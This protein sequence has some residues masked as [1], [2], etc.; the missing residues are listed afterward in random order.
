MKS[1]GAVIVDDE[2]IAR[3]T[4]SRMLAEFPDVQ[5][6]GQAESVEA[7]EVLID[8]VKADVVYLDIELIGESGFDL[9]PLLDEHV[10]VVFVTAFNQYAIRAFEVN[11]LDYLLKPVTRERLSETI[12]RLLGPTVPHLDLL[13]LNMDDVIL[14]H[15]NRRRRWLPIEQVSLIEASA[16]FTVIRSVNGLRATVWRPMREWERIL[17]A[18]QFV[19]IH[20]GRI[21]NLA[22]VEMFETLA[23]NRLQLH[24][25][26][27]NEACLA[28]RRLTPSL[29]RRLDRLLP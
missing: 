18:E 22:H 26:G 4:L 6:C 10:S 28:S 27:I 21:V 17:P 16:D 2:P 15:D 7:A 24:L 25:T 8:Q 12:R 5:V 19:R 3:Q 20:R 1:L 14:V 9:I 23:G 13:R 29:R 11:A